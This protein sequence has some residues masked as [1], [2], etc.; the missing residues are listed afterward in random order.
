M[1]AGSVDIQTPRTLTLFS[2][3]LKFFSGES[4]S[5]LPTIDPIHKASVFLSLSLRPEGLPKLSIVS[6]AEDK[7]SWLPLR[8]RVVL[9]AY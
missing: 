6:R 2:G 1:T 4:F 8:I 5:F 3:H 9:S 7:K